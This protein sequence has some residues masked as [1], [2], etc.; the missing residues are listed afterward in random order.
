MVANIPWGSMLWSLL[1]SLGMALVLWLAGTVLMWLIFRRSLMGGVLEA[2]IKAALLRHSW[3]A[4]IVLAA[5]AVQLLWQ[6]YP[7]Q[8]IP[9]LVGTAIIALIQ[10]PAIKAFFHDEAIV[11][12]L[13][14]HLWS[15]RSEIEKL[16]RIAD[17]SDLRVVATVGKAEATAAEERALTPEEKK[18]QEEIAFRFGLEQ[19]LLYRSQVDE[20]VESAVSQ[21]TRWA[22]SSIGAGLAWSSAVI[23]TSGFEYLLL[24]LSSVVGLYVSLGLAPQVSVAWRPALVVGLAAGAV[25][26]V[27]SVIICRSRLGWLRW[28]CIVC[29]A[30]TR[31]TMRVGDTRTHMCSDTCEQKL[32]NLVSAGR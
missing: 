12:R 20:M 27:A 11:A 6:G 17:K 18:L 9:V 15:R 30:G 23:A 14:S 1:V 29:G 22:Q 3:V 13:A 32:R 24:V 31:R 21:A 25:A 10:I 5:P 16:Q 26:L 2:R 19:R 7:E 8:A 4:A 28:Q